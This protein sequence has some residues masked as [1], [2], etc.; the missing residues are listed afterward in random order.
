MD[1]PNVSGLGR[2][3]DEIMKILLVINDMERFWSHRKPLAMA[4]QQRGWDVV[5][6]APE[7]EKERS[8][9]K[10]LGI[11]VY[12][13]PKH[14]SGM[15]VGAHM[16]IVRAIEKAIQDINP[17]LVYAITLRHAFYTGLAMRSGKIG[18][19]CVLTIAGLGALFSSNGL[20]A[21]TIRAALSPLLAF[22]FKGTHLIFQ[23]PDDMQ[24]LLNS[25]VAKKETSHL[26]KSSG[27]DLQQYPFTPIPENET[28]MI[29]F[30]SRLVR[31]KGLADFVHASRILREKNIAARFVVAGD[32]YPQNPNSHTRAEV[33]AWHDEGVIEWL[34]QVSN[35]PLLMQDSSIFVLPSYYREGVPKVIL[36]AMAT[37][38]PV[39]TT[40]MPGCRETVED[41]VTGYLI[42]IKDGRDIADKVEKLLADPALM[43]GMGKAAH[44]KAQDE[45]SVESVVS[46][47]L[48]VYDT[49][50]KEAEI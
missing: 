4:I 23:N 19:P 30:S 26:I 22:A 25:G 8:A 31:E 1:D 36:E 17:D 27:V 43:Q 49:A 5:V 13:I 12:E 40:N 33:Q 37:G 39:L 9:L 14:T 50:L 47:T 42:E 44:K 20:K 24:A 10:E 29:L 3:L 32:I 34:G 6:V 15:G 16:R 28:P 38:R 7:I 48:A 35:M 45:F 41:G 2:T 18:K 21:K 11:D 46:R